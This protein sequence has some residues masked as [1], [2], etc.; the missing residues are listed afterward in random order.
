MRF[1]YS[2]NGV[3]QGDDAVLR[4]I[5]AGFSKPTICVAP[6]SSG[7]RLGTTPE[8]AICDP[9]AP[10]PKPWRNAVAR[11]ERSGLCIMDHGG[12]PDWLWRGQVRQARARRYMGLPRRWLI[13]M[14]R[15]TPGTVRSLAAYQGGD[16]VAG[17]TML[18][19][20]RRWTYQIGW[21]S[22]EGRRLGAHNLLLDIAMRRAA[23][24]GVQVFDL[25]MAPTSMPGLR[26]FKQS[27]GALIEPARVVRLVR[28]DRRAP[29]VQV[30]RTPL[31]TDR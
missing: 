9:S 1:L 3:W 10:R 11:A 29:S 27:C 4:A 25:G 12:C 20:G 28:R 14:E 22:A 5:I 19:H 23:E 26:R 18:R 31:L 16:P 15:A 8:I 13:A 24:A 21:T 2:P 7:L 30:P 17:I 6:A